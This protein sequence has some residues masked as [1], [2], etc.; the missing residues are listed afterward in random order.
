[1][2]RLATQVESCY[3]DKYWRQLINVKIYV[4]G[5]LANLTEMGVQ[6]G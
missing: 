3:T 2:Q 5:N 1:M 6:I 4:V